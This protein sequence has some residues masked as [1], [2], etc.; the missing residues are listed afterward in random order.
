MNENNQAHIFDDVF[1]TM[2]EH[3]PEL[4]IPLINEV[5]QTNYPENTTIT[6][7]GDKRHLLLKL[8]ETDSCLNVGD[9]VY[10]FECESSPDNGVIAIRL[11]EYDVA[12]ALEGKRKENNTYVVEFPASCVIYLRHNSKTKTQEMV[13][14][15]MPDG[16]ELDYIIPVLKG[17][18]YTKEQ[19]FQK[20]LFVL[21][22]YY[23]LRYE[24][25]LELIE[26][27]EERRQQLMGEYE[28]ICS[29]LQQTLGQENPLGYS[30]LHKLMARVL[31]YILRKRKET[32]K[33]VQQVMGGHVLESWK[34]EMIRIGHA[35]ALAEQQKKLEAKILSKIKKGKTLI[36]ISEDLEED[37][38]V[39]Q[40]I[41][42]QLL[43]ALPSS[44]RI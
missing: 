20:K 10:H 36:Q 18:E 43:A 44:E 7:L 41:Y 33:G 40:P 5:F 32:K 26:Q 30:E 12:V 19:I 39:I 25:Q 35:E 13:L 28:E 15:R 23:I 14:L 3:I 4:M 1:R 8:V 24:K 21:L 9:K 6:R 42:D 34:E 38:T 29:R 11:F 2:E 31:D 16:R 17:Q 27:A 37:L 22:P